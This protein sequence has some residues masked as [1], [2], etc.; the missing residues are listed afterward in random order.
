LLGAAAVLGIST[1][2]FWREITPAE[3]FARV[4]GYIKANTPGDAKSSSADPETYREQMREYNRER[5]II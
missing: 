3:F 1:T 2:E 5:M 4:R